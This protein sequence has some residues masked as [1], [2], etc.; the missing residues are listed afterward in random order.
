MER[1]TITFNDGTK[2][3]Y[4]KGITYYEVSKD[5]KLANDILGVKVNNE[6]IPLDT[7]INKDTVVEFFDF[8]DLAGYKMYQAGLKF[9]FEAALKEYSPDLN[10]IYEH[11]VPKGILAEITGNKNLTKEDIVAIKGKMANIISEDHRF[12]K[13]NVLKKEAYAYYMS[14]NDEVKA[15]NVHS[16]T[17]EILPL[18]KLKDHIN[19]FYVELPYSTKVISKFD[20]IHLGKN[21]V[22]FIFPSK[23][24]NGLVPEYV[25]YQNI[26]DSF[27]QGKNWLEKMNMSYL[28]NLN[29][30]VANRKIKDFIHSSELLF[31]ETIA[32]VADDIY[33][34]PDKKLVLIAGPSSSGKTTTSNRLA[35]YLRMKGLDPVIISVDDYY[36]DLEKSPR[37]EFGNLDLECLM[38]LDLDLF[39]KQLNQLLNGE[40]VNLPA[41]DFITS[42]RIKTA[43]DIKLKENSILLIE[44]LHALNDDMIPQIDN[45]F[46]YKIYLS[47]FIPLNVDQHNYISTV[48]LRMIRRITRDYHARGIPV[49]STIERW[50]KVRSGEEKYIFPYIH[51]ADVIVNTAL[52]Y[53][54]GVL[55]E[56]I[57]PLLHTVG[58]DSKHYEEARRLIYF[59][60]KFYPIPGE[61]VSKDSILRE[62]IGG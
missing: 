47:P 10:V 11:S 56:Y 23:R 28:A 27:L 34:N 29:D 35:A 59:L 61:Y 33:K 22:V 42:K 57:T 58:M 24:T 36:Y 40:T 12:L 1:I 43:K 3:D 26:I 45:R 50:Q 16:S 60:D 17:A 19:Y 48:D 53:E 31:N 52:P 54:L 51:Q 5:Y 9:I 25:H 62:F 6:I 15:K 46:K 13:Y 14:I 20:V 2:K 38:A 18:Y 39:N 44:G 37:D 21:R 41:F 4:Q 30:A 49:A 7:K 8:N 55:K 32:N